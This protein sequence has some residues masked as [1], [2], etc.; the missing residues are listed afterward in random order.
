MR[1]LRQ[2]GLLL[3]L[4]SQLALN[5]F[6]QSELIITNS[7]TS[8]PLEGAQATTQAIGQ[9]SAV[10]VDGAG[11]FYICNRAQNRI[12]KVAKNGSISL[13]V[14]ILPVGFNK[15]G[16][17]PSTAQELD[18]PESLAVDSGGN[19]YI[20]DTGNNRILK[21]TSAGIIST[22]AGNGRLNGCFASS[23]DRGPASAATLAHPSGLAF[24]GAGGLYFAE[25]QCNR[26]R[27]ITTA[28]M[29]STVAGNGTKGYSGDGGLATAAQLFHPSDVAVDSAGNLYIADN[30]RIRKVTS[31]G[32]ISTVVGN[33]TM[34]FGGDGGQATAAQLGNPGG[35]TVDSM[36]TLYIADPDNHRIR[37]V[38][39]DGVISTAAGNGT[40]GYA[41]DGGPASAA[42]LSRPA[43][44]TVDSA[45]NMLIADLYNGRIRKVSPGGVIS[46]VAGNGTIVRPIKYSPEGIV[47]TVSQSGSDDHLGDGRA[48]PAAQFHSPL[49]VAVDSAGNLYVADRDNHRICKVTPAGIISTV[50]GNGALG[51]SGDGGPA[52]AARLNEPA[53][54]AVDAAG[55]LYIADTSN[56]LIR[57]VTT[58][59]IISTVAGNGTSG[60]SGDGEPAPAA[61]LNR[62]IGVA[63]DS[64]GT[65]YIVDAGNNRIRKVMTGI[66]STAAGTG[67]SGYG[68]DGGPAIEAP[69]NYV[70]AVAVDSAGN[71]YI[72]DTGNHRIRKVTPLGIISTV[73][74]NEKYNVGRD[75]G[76]ATAA[77]LQT[78]N[79]VAVDSAGNLYIAENSRIRKVTAG[80]ISRVAG[81]DRAAGYGGDGETAS[82]ARFSEPQDVAVDSA[83]NLY[84]ADTG[85][86]RIR[87]VT[88]AGIIS[89]VA[90]N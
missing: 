49:G 47:S 67:A 33:G 7:R 87:K 15:I 12:Y 35:M 26:I 56:A 80:T 71:L 79:G 45:G 6:T 66:I 74:G 24:D 82:D 58:G 27:K 69:L 48:A 73:A 16:G 32:V 86:H 90:G 53:D 76:I 77:W 75:P 59:G 5:G 23:G 60:Y 81:Q 3:F 72:A 52:T 64:A 51:Y 57:K 36:G 10:A 11:G 22:V 39:A 68:G 89:T 4:I 38:T 44:V 14:G 61:R 70:R 28:G 13:K 65:L 18:H 30:H 83:G 31:D 84:I 43:G 29:I 88:P 50:A 19:L 20:A 41:G 8:L 34:G 78:P 55:N 9:P 1:L 21:V 85:N 37:K 40:P 46:T 17:L 2:T 62:P 63:V 42:R 54:V 25:P